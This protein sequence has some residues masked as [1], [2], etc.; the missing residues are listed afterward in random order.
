MSGV[1]P[2]D[3]IID[4]ALAQL[5]A[6]GTQPAEVE[7][8]AN[9]LRTLASHNPRPCRVD[10]GNGMVIR[11]PGAPGARGFRQAAGGPEPTRH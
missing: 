7:R 4:G 2:A 9:M 6:L 3:T 1:G 10:L 5:R 8:V 11:L